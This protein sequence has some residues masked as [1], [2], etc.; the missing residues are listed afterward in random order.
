VRNLTTAVESN[1]IN[2]SGHANVT[3]S[4]AGKWAP[5]EGG[6]LDR[7]HKYARKLVK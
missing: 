1:N 6:S 2:K 7:K 3:I 5:T 4:L